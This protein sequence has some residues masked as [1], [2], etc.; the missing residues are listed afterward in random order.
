MSGAEDKKRD[1]RADER[2]GG[3]TPL[4]FRLS[5]GFLDIPGVLC[6]LW[7]YWGVLWNADGQEPEGR[8]VKG[9]VT[10]YNC[11]VLGTG[12]HRAS[13]RSRSRR[14]SDG[15]CTCLNIS[16]SLDRCK[17][18]VKHLFRAEGFQGF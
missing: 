10:G 7:S 4:A 16:W 18:L 14:H 2:K 3:D 11:F 8:G 15:R 6:V 9:G 17:E 1:K 5:S 13:G 12:S